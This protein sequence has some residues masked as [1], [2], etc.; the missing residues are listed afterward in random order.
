MTRLLALSML[1]SAFAGDSALAEN[2]ERIEILAYGIS[3][4]D[5]EAEIPKDS[6]ISTRMAE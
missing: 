1:V 2:V 6:N 5:G 3:H 4:A